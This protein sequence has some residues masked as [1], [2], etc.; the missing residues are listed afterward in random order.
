MLGLRNSLAVSQYLGGVAVSASSSYSIALDSSNEYV[1][2]GDIAELDG[3][4]AFSISHWSKHTTQANHAYWSKYDGSSKIKFVTVSGELQC[5][6]G[7]ARVVDDDNNH[8]DDEWEHY[9]VVYD[10]GQASAN[11]RLL[12]YRNGLILPNTTY[13]GTIPTTSPDLGSEPFYIGREDGGYF[14]G[15]FDEVGL[16]S[17]ALSEKAVETL[18][19][20][21]VPT[22]LSQDYV[23]YDKSGNLIGYWKMEEGTGTSV[24]NTANAGTY[25]GSFVNSI[26]WSSDV[27]T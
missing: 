24:A 16:W 26:A 8:V 2:C 19:S 22:D 25:T 17:V 14:T 1:N 21:G 27:P 13:T 6:M 4:T 12:I 20:L 10:G 7:T 18:Y 23:N 5:W 15:N 3:V 9:V 11:D